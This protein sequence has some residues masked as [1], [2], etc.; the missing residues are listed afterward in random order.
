MHRAGRTGWPDKLKVHVEMNPKKKL[1]VTEMG[2]LLTWL[3]KM[4][5]TEYI[6]A[7]WRPPCSM[8]KSGNTGEIVATFRTSIGWKI[9]EKILQVLM[10][11][12]SVVTA[13]GLKN[14]WMIWIDKTSGMCAMED[15]LH[16][17]DGVCYLLARVWPRR[18]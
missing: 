8:A 6:K 13:E 14:D 11:G 18:H 1:Y 2:K 16:L 3:K 4:K 12:M 17:G 10:P 9:D 15:L 5:V 7:E